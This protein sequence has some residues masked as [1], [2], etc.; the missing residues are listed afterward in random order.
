MLT[1]KI[2]LKVENILK[3]IAYSESITFKERVE[4]EKI[5]N[6]DQSVSAWLKRAQRKQ[7]NRENNDKVDKLIND[8]DLGSADPQ[9]NFN[10]KE[11]DLGEWFLGAPSWITRS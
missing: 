9:S 11:E 1:S 6:Q 10:P 7:L 2:R 8:L 3:K 5:A 4:I